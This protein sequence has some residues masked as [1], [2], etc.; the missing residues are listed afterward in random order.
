MR[1]TA[2]KGRLLVSLL[3]GAITLGCGDQNPAGLQ[4]QGLTRNGLSDVPYA[5]VY[6]PKFVAWTYGDYR[7]S[8][9]TTYKATGLVPDAY[10]QYAGSSPI[11]TVL[12]FAAA[13]PGKLYVHDDEPDQYCVPPAT[14]AQS[15]HDFVTQIR[16]VDPTAKFSPAGFAEPNG[17]CGGIHSVHYAEM[18]W[19]E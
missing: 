12:E 17:E 18:F 9:I 11:A 2:G 3:A 10:R 8:P 6:Q 4:H 14:Y 15:Y 7:T 19:N 13:H 16:A 1:L 5:P